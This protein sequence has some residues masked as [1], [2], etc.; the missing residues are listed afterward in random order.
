MSLVK[1]SRKFHKW[2]MLFLGIQFI[3]WSLSGLYMVVF[4]IDFIHGDNLV[5][6]HQTPINYH[7]INYTLADLITDHPQAENIEIGLFINREVYRFS[8][9]Q[10]DSQQNY[11]IDA[12]T[13]KQLS[14]LIEKMAIKAA[15]HYYSGDGVV[16][17]AELITE[18]APFE[19]SR[20]NLPA[21]RVNFSDF[22]N[23][24]IYISAQ[25]GKLVTKRHNYWRVFDYMFSF[26]VMDYEKEDVSNKLL[27]WFVIMALFSVLF[28]FILTYFHTIKGKLKFRKK[29]RINKAAIK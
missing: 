6:N 29:Q 10:E 7:N 15:T 17:D 5:I 21:W 13:G 25:S 22:S 20:R 26:H 23:P 24:S 9:K 2:L 11:L 19:L 3:V 12:K 4:D 1:T 8:I 28:G 14:P 27:F 18:D 16:T